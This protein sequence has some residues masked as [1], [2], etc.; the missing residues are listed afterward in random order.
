MM[1]K[2]KEL[3]LIHLQATCRVLTEERWRQRN[4]TH[5]YTIGK[6]AEF[7]DGFIQCTDFKQERIPEKWL[8]SF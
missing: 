3:E 6:G 4:T 7:C 8:D 1:K 2:L 5:I